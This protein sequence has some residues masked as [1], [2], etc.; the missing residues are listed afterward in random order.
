LRRLFNLSTL[1]VVALTALSLV[2]APAPAY[3]GGNGDD[4]GG[5]RSSSR[6]G[7]D[8]DNRGGNDNR[9][10]DRD[11]NNRGGNDNRGNDRDNNNRGGNNGHKTVVVKEGRDDRGNRDDDRDRRD[12]DRK[13]DWERHNIRVV[14]QYTMD[15]NTPFSASVCGVTFTGFLRE[16]Q[17]YRLYS[18]GFLNFK[19]VAYAEAEGRDAEGR[20]VTMRINNFEIDRIFSETVPDLAPY[21][22][23][24]AGWVNANLDI[25]VEVDA[26]YK[27]VIRSNGG[28]RLYNNW[29]FKAV[30]SGIKV[31]HVEF[32]A[33][34]CA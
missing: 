33:T 34:N 15:D 10:N 20:R 9:G 27:M 25:I 6:G 5:N 13:N 2:I 17:E 8:R 32:S 28:P 4:R 23:D 31:N 12:R 3:A 1:A 11:S 21:G 14:R 19:Y 22:G 29:T 18:N 30:H 7:D 16:H 24:L 26:G